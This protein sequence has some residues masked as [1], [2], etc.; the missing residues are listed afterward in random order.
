MVPVIEFSKKRDSGETRAVEIELINPPSQIRSHSQPVIFS[1]KE[2]VM[3]KVLPITLR[4]GFYSEDGKLLSD[5]VKLIF[6]SK[7]DDARLREKSHTFNFKKELINYNNKTIV[8][9]LE[10][11]VENKF[12]SYKKHLVDVHI[13]FADEFD[14]F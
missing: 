3:D 2:P 5:E 8:F 9:L 13:S 11:P 6:D 1:Q 12:I 4:A 10:K 7:E 14:D